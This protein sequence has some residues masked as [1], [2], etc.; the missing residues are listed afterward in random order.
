MAEGIKQEEKEYIESEG[1]RLLT[2]SLMFY[3]TRI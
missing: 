3:Q 2:V 1:K